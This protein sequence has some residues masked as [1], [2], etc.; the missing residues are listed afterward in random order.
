[1]GSVGDSYDNALAL[2]ALVAEGMGDVRDAVF[3]K[4]MNPGCW[5][6][7]G[8]AGSPLTQNEHEHSHDGRGRLPVV[9]RPTQTHCGT[10]LLK[11]DGAKALKLFTPMGVRP[12]CRHI[13]MPTDA[14]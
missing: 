3:T 14:Q 8:H 1:V 10:S 4:P 2:F 6:L 5:L 9:M 12:L 7:V 11:L 13:R